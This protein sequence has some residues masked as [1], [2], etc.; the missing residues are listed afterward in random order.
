MRYRMMI[1]NNEEAA[2]R[3]GAEPDDRYPREVIPV[4]R[5]LVAATRRVALYPIFRVLE[6]L[7]YPLLSF[8]TANVAYRMPTPDQIRQWG[9]LQAMPG[10]FT[11]WQLIW[12]NMHFLALFASAGYLIEANDDWSH[13]RV[14]IGDPKA[15]YMRR[16]EGH[17][18][19]TSGI[20]KKFVRWVEGTLG[21]WNCVQN[22]LEYD[23]HRTLGQMSCSLG[24]I[25]VLTTPLGDEQ[26]RLRGLQARNPSVPLDILSELVL[27]NYSAMTHLQFEI[28]WDFM[29]GCFNQSHVKY[30]RQMFGDREEIEVDDFR[31]ATKIITNNF[32]NLPVM[33]WQLPQ[34]ITLD[35][36]IH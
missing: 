7:Y 16:R 31:K 25:N 24:H 20:R 1:D 4:E 10:L 21:V 13:F 17:R 29:R 27:H 35:R 30:F 18:I 2:V 34:K 12:V 19:Y 11:R 15:H 22:D 8:Q 33:H 26:N 5:S 23:Y 14:T 6:F 32:T 9:F 28:S 3:L 36:Y